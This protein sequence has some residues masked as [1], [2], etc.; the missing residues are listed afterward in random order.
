MI[1]GIATILTLTIVRINQMSVNHQANLVIQ[2]E[3]LE[4]DG[5]VVIV[6]N[7]L[8]SFSSTYCEE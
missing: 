5:T 6:D 8:L 4:N 3:C 7:G 1:V 2:E